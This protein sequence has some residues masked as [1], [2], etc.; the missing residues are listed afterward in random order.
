MIYLYFYSLNNGFRPYYGDEY[1]YLKNSESLAETGDFR[2]S[3]SYSGQ[4]SK[5]GGF[6]PHGP[7][8]P[9]LYS[10]PSL[11]G[12]SETLKIPLTNWILFLFSVL[13][14]IWKS[15]LRIAKWAQVLLMLGSP[16]TLF[17]GMNLM[18]ELLHLAIAIGIYLGIRAFINQDGF[19]NLI[20]VLVCIGLGG[21][22]RDTWFFAYLILGLFLFER[23]PKLSVLLMVLGLVLPYLS[24]TL[25]HESVPNVFSDCINHLKAG[26]WTEALG[27]LAYNA[28]RNIYFIFT[29]SEGLYYWVWKIWILITMVLGVIFFKKSEAIQLGFGFLVLQVIF[30]IV[31]YKTYQWTEWRMLSPIALLVNLQLMEKSNRSFLPALGLVFSLASFIGILPFQKKLVSLRE[32][33]DLQSLSTEL[34]SE[35]SR[36]E[37]AL[38]RI[39]PML[40]EQYDWAALP[41]RNE[42]GQLIRYLLPYYSQKEAYSTHSLT[43]ANGQLMIRS[44]KILNQ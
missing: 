30:S 44:V 13:V 9:I 36:L 28:K 41:I 8:Y 43:E 7:A 12:I 38:I 35:I 16:F 23:N 32:N 22:F 5:V 18:P 29:Y 19:R 3:F 14:L 40:L 39:D 2:A 11:F 6:D 24:Q 20:W 31:L 17:Y 1:F 27:E 25:F 4:G 33:Q 37:N 34:I 15:D 26:N 42:S 21:F 10:I